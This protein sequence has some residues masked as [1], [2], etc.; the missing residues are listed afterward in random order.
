MPQSNND[1][2]SAQAYYEEV[3]SGLHVRD[4]PQQ[5]LNSLYAA[6]GDQIYYNA[7][8]QHEANLD[9][10]GKGTAAE[11][12]EYARWGVFMQQLQ[13][14]QPIW[15]QQFNNGQRQSNAQRSI[16]E[17]TDIYNAGTEPATKTPQGQAI[18]AL[19]AQY[20][21][22]EAAY[23]Q[24]GSTSNYSSAQSHVKDAWIAQVDQIAT[25]QPA[26]RVHHFICVRDALTF[27]NQT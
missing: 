26:T 16:N 22:A 12:E 23:M 10:A 9:G 2:Y 8:V 24:A 17:L 14:T 7:L 25:Q 5:Y 19:L 20:Q 18:G 6:N 27:T 1:T 3:A 13:K 11:N 15:W 4:T 21:Q